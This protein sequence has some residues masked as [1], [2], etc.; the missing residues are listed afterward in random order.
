MNSSNPIQIMTTDNNALT[1]LFTADQTPDADHHAVVELILALLADPAAL[2]ELVHTMFAGRTL[3]TASRPGVQRIL[4]TLYAYGVVEDVRDDGG[5]ICR[6]RFRAQPLLQM[7]H[8]MK[9]RDSAD[10]QSKTLTAST[11]TKA[12]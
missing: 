5:K 11:A 1:T 12:L 7:L 2:P 9:H 10:D 4:Q 3:D 8:R 6:L